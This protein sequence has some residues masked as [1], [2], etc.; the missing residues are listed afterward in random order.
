MDK[1]KNC[2]D[3]YMLIREYFNKIMRLILILKKRKNIRNKDLSIIS[4]NCIGGVLYKELGLKFNSPTI[5]LYFYPKDYIRFLSNLK[6]YLQLDLVFI[7]EKNI[8]FPIAMLG[9]IKIYFMHYQTEDEAKLKWKQ[10]CKRVNFNNLY[11]IMVE[12]DECTE[13]EIAMFDKL[14]YKNKVIFTHKKF[15]KYKSSFYITGYEEKKEIGNL[16]EFRNLVGEKYYDEF[17]FVKWFNGS[18]KELK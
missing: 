9:D 3:I 10:R 18:G 13:E 7:K 2:G 5:N 16:M 6:Y 8:S 1:R 17:D 4:S 12:K 15:D 14:P 11:I